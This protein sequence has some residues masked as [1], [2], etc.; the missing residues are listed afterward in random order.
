MILVH[1]TTIDNQTMTIMVDWDGEV[2]SIESITI[3]Q[4]ELLPFL[5]P[6]CDALVDSIDWK[7]LY[8][9]KQYND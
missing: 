4:I 9:Q 1:S 2:E 7:E 3:N 5:A 8:H 6:Y